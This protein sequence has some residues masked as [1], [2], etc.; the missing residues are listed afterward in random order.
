MSHVAHSLI[1]EMQKGIAVTT[2]SFYFFLFSRASPL[3]MSIWQLL[4]FLTSSGSLQRKIMS[5][6]TGDFSKDIFCVLC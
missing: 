4:I 5:S 2:C 3:D 6:R 1:N